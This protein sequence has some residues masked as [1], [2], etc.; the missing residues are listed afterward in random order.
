MIT[1]TKQNILC[2][3]SHCILPIPKIIFS[4]YDLRTGV[5]LDELCKIKVNKSSKFIGG[6]KAF[7]SVTTDFIQLEI[8][9]KLLAIFYN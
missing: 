2:F 4:F 8:K 9:I 3:F 1:C 7:K 5:Q 6:V